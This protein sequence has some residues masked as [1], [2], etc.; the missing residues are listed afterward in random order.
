M[1]YHCVFFLNWDVVG[2]EIC[3]VWGMNACGKYVVLTKD[4][5]YGD[6]KRVPGVG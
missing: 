3:C 4:G 1:K 6:L 5:R 2:S